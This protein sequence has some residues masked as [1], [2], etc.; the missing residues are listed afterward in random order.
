MNPRP[1]GEREQNLLQLYTY[2]QY[3]RLR[4]NFSRVK[5]DD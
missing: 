5:P 2:C 3:R 4:A 1:L